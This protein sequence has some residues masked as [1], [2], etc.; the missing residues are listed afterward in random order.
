MTNIHNNGKQN[1]ADAKYLVSFISLMSADTKGYQ[2]AAEQM[3]EAVQSQPGFIAVYSARNEQGIGI[4]NSYW[5]SVQAIVD[6]K[7]DATHS[8]IQE[9]GKKKWYQWYQTQ[10]CE[11]QRSYGS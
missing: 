8:A 7:A 5:S 10:V 1:L 4:T 9:T 3:M 11:I 6:W 2:Q